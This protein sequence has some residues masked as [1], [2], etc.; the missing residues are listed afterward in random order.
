V[1]RASWDQSKVNNMDAE[2]ITK[3]SSP[4]LTMVGIVA[5]LDPPRPEAIEAVG[6]ANQA[7]IT[8]KMI[9]G[10][11]PAT[12]IAIGKMLGLVPPGADNYKAYTGP[13]I[14]KMTEE[15]LQGIVLDCN[16][17]ARA[18]PENKT[19]IVKALQARGQICSMTGDG[20]NDAPALKKAN[21]GVA[22]GI[23]GTD[24]SKEAAKMVLADDN[25]AT[26]VK[27]VREGRRVWDNLVKI[28]LYNMPVNL[29]QGLSVF[30]AYVLQLEPLKGD[31]RYYSEM[32]VPLTAIQVLYVNMITSV[33]MGLM[34]A[35][36]PAEDTIMT[37]PPRRNDKRLF[38]K[39]V[40][41]HCLFVSAIL[42]VLV[43]FNF[44]FTLDNTD[45]DADFIAELLAEESGRRAGAK[46]NND[47]R[48]N[49]ARAVAFNMLVFG[50]IAYALNC[51]NVRGT[52]DIRT[53]L[54]GNSW[55]WISISITVAL[56]LFLT[57]TPGV[58]DFFSNAP[59]GLMEWVRI[60]G[61]S[62]VVFIL[63]EIEKQVGPKYLLPIVRPLMESM[64]CMGSKGEVMSQ[65][66]IQ[67][68][69]FYATSGSSVG[70]PHPHPTGRQRKLSGHGSPV[71]QPVQQSSPPD[72]KIDVKPGV[73]PVYV[74]HGTHVQAMQAMPPTM[75]W[76][77]QTQFDATGTLGNVGAPMRPQWMV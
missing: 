3:A 53:L 9:T 64:G 38:G 73:V 47:P 24:V 51:R 10:D 27:A 68:T 14:D 20:V 36:E 22:M 66:E 29:A 52:P 59:I 23:T 55:C 65:E 44:W 25:F 56:Q 62:V 76:P 1:C 33:T 57:Y 28:L 18:S 13:E 72:M 4:F 7:G 12:A 54:F 61:F 60:L 46:N 75:G 77:T 15:Q 74:P 63:V 26:I 42:V 32:A 31:D 8:V 2:I 30:F 45:P 71:L 58:N 6:V 11:H 70:M 67:N 35:M 49:K 48:M 34:L 43:E 19:N 69:H 50:E 37:R 16:V 21:I 5:I 39:M 40:M 41:W 17:F